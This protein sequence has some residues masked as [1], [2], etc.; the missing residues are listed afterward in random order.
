M[1]LHLVL[2][3]FFLGFVA[4][5]FSQ[6]ALNM[7]RLGHW[8]DDTLPIASPGSLNLQYSGI[9]G[10]TVNGREIAVVGGALHVLFFD[11][12]KPT[13]PK[14][15]GKFAGHKPTIWREF[16]SYKNRVYAV[17]DGTDEGM[18]VFDM[19]KA[20]DNIVRTY[21]SNEFFN[22]SHT[23]TLDTLSGRIYLNGTNAASQGSLVL[24]VKNNPDKP[25]VL[26]VIPNL[27]CGY[28]HDSYVR[29]DTLYA[30]SGN[31]GYCIYDFRDYAQPKFLAA[32]NTG[33]YNHNSWLTGDGRYAYY[34][35]EI[36]QGRPV[37]IVDLQKLGS[38]EIKAVGGFLDN[39]LDPAA[40][41]K[42]AIAHNLYIRDNLLFNS[43]Y[44]DGLLV[45]DISKPLQ[46][47]LRAFYDTH[48]QNTQYN[49]YYGN[50][51][52][53]PWLPS[54]VILATD[55]QNGLSI[56]KLD[57][58]VNTAAPTD[59][60]PVRLSP[61]PATEVLFVEI[62]GSHSDARLRYRLLSPTGQVL[63]SGESQGQPRLEISL[64]SAPAGLC[65]LYLSGENGQTAVRR[66]VVAK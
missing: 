43:Q 2:P 21:Y 13:E 12:T 20:P 23:I 47:V 29:R 32:E 4:P 11:V 52:N 26:A 5:V 56:L 57:N 40:T 46:P 33:G 35:E 36:P 15:I 28:I 51:G 62:P 50:W 38:G 10:M 27:Q 24:S 64:A 65:F 53:Y 44:E 1:K 14:L 17:S 8:D 49:T 48:P 6:N 16:K 63:A 7:T 9:W 34:T 18:M 55:M 59:P 30:S 45:Y 25:E 22:S 41:E 19:N 60:L 3:L 66:V 42:K 58:S 31:N 61:N 37:S 54:G 39:L